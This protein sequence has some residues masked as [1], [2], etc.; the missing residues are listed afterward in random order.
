MTLPIL[1]TYASM[2]Y[3]IFAE[4]LLLNLN[5]KIVNHQVHFY[6]V[7]KEILLHLL[8]FTR[9]NTPNLKIQLI[10]YFNRN[11]LHDDKIDEQSSSFYFSSEFAQ[12]THN[13]LKIIAD[14]LSKFSFIHFIDCDVVC[15]KEPDEEF[16]DKYSEYDVVFQY[17]AGFFSKYELHHETLHWIW[18][19]TGNTTFKNTKRTQEFLKEWDQFQYLNQTKNDQECLYEYFRNLNISDIRDY[20]NAKLYTYPPNE[21]TNGYWLY[22][23]IGNLSDTYF[24]HANHVSGFERKKALLEKAGFWYVS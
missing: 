19:C 21:F 20:P 13:K 17:D 9:E 6:C 18:A 15:C 16:Y 12:F 7:D 8:E 5:K 2:G 24:F 22:H 1:V 3:K 23:N 10:P 4:N 14:A 11:I